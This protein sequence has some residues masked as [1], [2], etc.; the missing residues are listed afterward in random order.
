MREESSIAGISCT[1]KI[2]VKTAMEKLSL[3][4]EAKISGLHFLIQ[5]KQGAAFSLFGLHRLFMSFL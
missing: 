2:S 3:E 4:F 1:R 5:L